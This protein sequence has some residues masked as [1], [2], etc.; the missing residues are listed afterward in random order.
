MGGVVVK[1]KKE[2]ISVLLLFL[3][4]VKSGWR[5]TGEVVLNYIVMLT[6]FLLILLCVGITK[7]HNGE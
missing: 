1:V 3:F 6:T 2:I 5:G 4:M 7:I